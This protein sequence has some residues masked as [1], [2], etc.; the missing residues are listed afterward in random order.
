VVRAVLAVE[1]SKSDLAVGINE[2]L[3]I[4]ATNPLDRT[5]IVRILGAE[6]AGMMS[7][8]FSWAFP[9]ACT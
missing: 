1:F 3:L 8:T 4:E 9:M 2:G 5:Y 7:F 6:I